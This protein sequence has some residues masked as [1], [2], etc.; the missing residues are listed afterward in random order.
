MYRKATRAIELQECALV[1]TLRKV[2]FLHAAVWALLGLAFAIFAQSVLNWTDPTGA[3]G[4]FGYVPRVPTPPGGEIFVRFLGIATFV[5]SMFMVLVAQKIEAV[6]W[7]SWGF[8][9][10]DV[11]VLLVALLHLAFGLPPKASAAPWWLISLI[12]LGFA[13]ALLWGLF[14]AQQ[15]QPIIEA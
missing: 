8:V 12:S 15:D 4:W 13:I 2:L 14:K 5:L 6:W 9:M 7:W 1:K 3:S 10:A 11:L